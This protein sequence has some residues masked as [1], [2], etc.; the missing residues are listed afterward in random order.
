MRDALITPAA[1][2]RAIVATVLLLALGIILGYLLGGLGLVGLV[3]WV[4]L[5]AGVLVGAWLALRAGR[6]LA[7][8]GTAVAALACW[9]AFFVMP[10]A[11]VWTSL[12]FLGVLLVARGTAADT[13]RP[14]AWPL[15]LPRIAIGWALVDNAQDHFLTNWLPAVQGSGFLQVAGGAANRAP[16]HPL[17]PLYQSF[18]RGVVLPSADTWAGLTICGELTFGL[19][20]ALG[21]LTPVGALGAMWLNGNYMLM[22]GFVAHGAYVD[23]VFFAGELFSLIAMVGLVYGLDAALCQRVPAWLA[24]ALMGLPSPAEEPLQRRRPA[25]QMT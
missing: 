20:L 12:F 21:F 19:L 8:V 6:P 10:P 11:W 1:V 17:D 16:M 14:A 22:K 3:T 5:V 24:Q 18:L 15:L 9:I 4:I 7:G 13:T 2:A 23:K 25:P